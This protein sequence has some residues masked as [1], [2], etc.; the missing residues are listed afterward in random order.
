M[1]IEEVLLP[2]AL[3]EAPL[4]RPGSGPLRVVLSS[5][6]SDSHTW[7]LVFLQLLLEHM[8]HEVRNIGACAPDELIVQTCLRE[9][10][11][12]LIISTVNGH[13]NI[14]GERLIQRVRKEAQLRDLPVAIGGKLGV[15]G[16]GNAAH[17]ERLLAAGF[18]AV[19]EA[20]AGA[21][22]PALFERFV[23]RISAQAQRPALAEAAP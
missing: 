19:F 16:A 23:Q 21:S 4:T 8:G 11:D 9:R 17:V 5:V 10:P 7:N 3:S 15:L 13:G 20:S 14:D 6:S 22:A 12:L 1:S 18:T 2:E